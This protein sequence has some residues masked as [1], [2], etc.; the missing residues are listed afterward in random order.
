MF[1]LGIESAGEGVGYPGHVRVLAVFF[2][3]GKMAVF[4][5]TARGLVRL[6][7]DRKG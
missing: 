4:K 6:D 7:G 5:I 2:R 1:D 3:D